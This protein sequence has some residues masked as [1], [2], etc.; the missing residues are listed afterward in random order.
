MRGTHQKHFCATR[1]EYGKIQYTHLCQFSSLIQ[2][3]KTS[4]SAPCSW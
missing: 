2:S 4:D 3:R 1:T